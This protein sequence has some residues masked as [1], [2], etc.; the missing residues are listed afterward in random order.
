[1]KKEKKRRRKENKMR[2]PCFSKSKKIAKKQ[3]NSGRK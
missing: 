3:S 1:M 2:K